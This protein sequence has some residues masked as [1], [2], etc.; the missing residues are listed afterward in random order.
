MFLSIIL[1][2]YNMKKTKFASYCLQDI[3]KG[4]KLCVQGKKLVLFISGICSRDCYYCSLSKTRK[5]KDFVWANERK[6][7]NVKDINKEIKESKAT[8]A[9]ITGGDP[10]LV[11][12]RTIKFASILKKHGKD[13]HIHIYLPTKLVSISKLK[14]ISKYIDEVRFHPEFLCSKNKN[15]NSDI[16]KIKLSGLFWNKPDIGIEL[17][18]IPDKKREILNFILKLEN[19]V[20][21]VNLNEL[22]LSETNFN[23]LTRNYKLKQG[24]Y[25]VSGSKEAGLWILKQLEKKGTK[26]RVHLCT[27]ETKD[28][29]QYKNRLLLHKILPFGKRT[30]EGTIRYF[31]VYAR[32]KKEF[33]KLKKQKLGYAD[34]KKMRVIMPKKKVIKLIKKYKIERVEE[35][36]TYDGAE[37]LREVLE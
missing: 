11:F 18:L 17:P 22:E 7:K 27:A 29:H 13:F 10:L 9:G 21:F 25:V 6:C 2:E 4:C 12:N 14:K 28:W 1:V 34:N 24:G 37:V 8:S 19:Y 23:Y 35:Y 32:N 16:N 5:N 26:L 31:A 36:P 15:I 33:N 30:E 3:A 20:G